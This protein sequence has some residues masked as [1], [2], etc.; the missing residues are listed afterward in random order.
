MY[1]T[2]NLENYNHNLEQLHKL[3]YLVLSENVDETQLEPETLKMRQRYQA[4]GVLNFSGT[5][6]EERKLTVEEIAAS[7]NRLDEHLTDPYNSLIGRI[8]GEKFCFEDQLHWFE[9][10]TQ[11]VKD[12][13]SVKFEPIPLTKE[14]EAHVRTLRK[15]ISILTELEQSIEKIKNAKK[16]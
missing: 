2:E 6:S 8:S 12:G 1:G 10:R 14:E 4:K 11:I 13:E 5:F 15:A 3:K 9:N 16:D 7:Y